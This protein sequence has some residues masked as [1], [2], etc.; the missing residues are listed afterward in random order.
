MIPLHKKKKPGQK[1]KTKLYVDTVITGYGTALLKTEFQW[2]V[3]E[4][5]SS[6]IPQDPSPEKVSYVRFWTLPAM[7]HLGSLG[8]A[9]CPQSTHI[10]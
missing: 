8:P 7:V 5:L 1:N 10:N 3:T 6:E 2:H 9:A 4:S